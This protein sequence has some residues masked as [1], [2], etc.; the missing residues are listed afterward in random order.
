MKPEII[1]IG[2]GGHC[3]SCIDVIE[4][5]DTYQIVGIV[6]VQQKLH[7]KIFG[8]E[9]IAIDTDIPDLVKEYKYFFITL[10]Q[11]KSPDLRIKFFRQIKE[12]GVEL[13]SIIS[14][15]AY[16]SKHAHVGVGTIVMHHALVNAGAEVGDNCI[17]NTNALIEHDVKIN[18]HCHVATSAVVNGGTH[19]E[20]ASFVGS[21]AICREAISISQRSIIGCNE[22]V[23]K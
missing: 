18:N 19:V 7:S 12:L 20:E 2:G 14:P 9:I 15:R 23:K 4:Q 1:L 6:D 21:G 11:I 3:R 10:G 17:I 16:V 5:C 13:P 22:T 8:Y